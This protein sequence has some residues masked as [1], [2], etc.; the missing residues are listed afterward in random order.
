MMWGLNSVSRQFIT[1]LIQYKFKL[2]T[3]SVLLGGN[4]LLKKYSI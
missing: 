2:A 4:I 3:F 1:D